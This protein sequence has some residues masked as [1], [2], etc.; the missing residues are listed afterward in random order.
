MPFYKVRSEGST[1]VKPLCAPLFLY[2]NVILFSL[3][4]QYRPA[5]CIKLNVI[6]SQ[7]SLQHR[8]YSESLSLWTSSIVRN[9]K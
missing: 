7:R 2:L 4:F 8:H 3:L 9:S 1:D 6:A 5:V